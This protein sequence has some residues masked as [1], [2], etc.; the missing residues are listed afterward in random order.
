MRIGFR[1]YCLHTHSKIAGVTRLPVNLP[2]YLEKYSGGFGDFS[3]VD[4]T[5]GNTFFFG[6]CMDDGS[7]T[8]GVDMQSRQTYLKIS[9]IFRNGDTCSGLEGL[10][11]ID[12]VIIL[13]CQ[14]AKIRFG[15]R[16]KWR[17]FREKVGQMEESQTGSRQ[18]R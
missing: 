2:N 16:R 13:G 9:G 17:G 5:H 8:A 1:V 4:Q 11:G 18:E 10:P 6:H 3:G 14:E 7:N 12:N 15:P